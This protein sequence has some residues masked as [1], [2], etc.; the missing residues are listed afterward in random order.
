MANATHLR[1]FYVLADRKFGFIIDKFKQDVPRSLALA[2]ITV[3]NPYNL[4]AP[5]IKDY[6][7]GCM[8]VSIAACRRAN[9]DWNQLT[10]PLCCA[11]AWFTDTNRVSYLLYSAYPTLFTTPNE[12]FWKC[13][14]LKVVIQDAAFDALW[15]M[16]GPVAG[17]PDGIYGQLKAKVETLKGSL[18]GW[19]IPK[20]RKR[21]LLDLETTFA[22]AKLYGPLT[23]TGPGRP[24]YL[25]GDDTSRIFVE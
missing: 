13:A 16:T 1:R 21:V 9:V 24:P 25:N 18:P 12:D 8:L 6:H 22:L 17:K 7:R 4:N 15:T 19:T 2:H 5:A 23:S 10:D 11:Y 3:M 14:Y 20:L